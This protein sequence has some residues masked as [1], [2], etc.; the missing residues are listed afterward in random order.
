MIGG[1]LDARGVASGRVLSMDCLFDKV[2][3]GPNRL[4][5]R[6]VM[7]PMTR[8]RAEP[9]GTPGALAAEYYSQ[10]AGLGLII[11]E[12]TQP[13]EDGQGYMTTPGI[14]T[15]AHVAG[16]RRVTDAVH[17]RGGRIVIQLAHAG[18]MSH[19]DN[20][21]HGRPGLAPSAVGPGTAIFTPS[22]MQP[23]PTPLEMSNDQIR[24]AI[25]E[26]RH[27]ARRAIEAGADGV[28]IH[29]GAGYLIH[30][31]LAVSSNC[32]T[33][34]WGGTIARRARFAI[35][36]ARAVSEEIGAERIGIRLSPGA[37]I[38]GIEEGV[39]AE[40]LYRHLVVEL[41]H[42]DLGYLHITQ[43]G[44]DA[45]VRTLRKLWGGA[46]ILN[47]PGRPREAIGSDIETGLA[48]F[49]AYGQ[50]VLANPDFERRL[51]EGAPFND[52][53]RA[54]FYGGGAAGYIDYPRL[55]DQPD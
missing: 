16:W 10:R 47:R 37:N 52:P 14:Y 31:F 17:G 2:K 48:D 40:A 26:F 27:A 19:P 5:N 36:V 54:T 33:D 18:R 9:D 29:G 41:D 39:E 46:F 3:L 15:D 11:T 21:P 20:T 6:L 28:E 53:D 13:S 32:R 44:E 50:L 35:E 8:N 38:F 1:D 43:F 55:P 23:I 45:V 25:G 34:D 12:S 7:A 24:T 30:Q 4:S 49:E 42:L 51:R 22:G